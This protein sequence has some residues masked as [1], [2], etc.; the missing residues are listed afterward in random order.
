MIKTA[1]SRHADSNKAAG[2][3]LRRS[4][5]RGE[6][7]VL[8]ILLFTEGYQVELLLEEIKKYHDSK[9]PMLGC[10]VPLLLT[11]DNVLS[12]AVALCVFY[13]EKNSV[14]T[15][16]KKAQ[17]TEIMKT[18]LQAASIL[19]KEPALSS[20]TLLTFYSGISNA[21]LMMKSFYNGLG[22]AFNYIG[23]IG[24]NPLIHDFQI[25]RD[26][27]TAALI[28]GFN[29][30]VITGHGWQ[31]FGEP[32]VLTHCQDNKVYQ[33]N[34]RPAPEVY[35]GADYANLNTLQK[36]IDFYRK[37]PIGIPAAGG[38]HIIRDLI[39]IEENAL[40][41]RNQIPRNTVVTPL[42]FSA[43]SFISTASQMV[44][45]ARP[46]A[47]KPT[48]L[49]VIECIGRHKLMGQKTQLQLRAMQQAAGDNSQ[50]LGFCSYGEVGSFSSVPD[51][52]N[53][54]MVIM[55]GDGDGF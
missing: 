28:S 48:T 55:A 45:K 40:V 27:L 11:S 47:D 5:I 7:P 37:H 15:I 14:K 3:V 2:E 21:S 22:P 50:L 33:I 20:G 39:D 18:A 38:N 42:E 10:C 51:Q 25:K 30:N 23:G 32:M 1:F 54:T 46:A 35:F 19:K 36:K 44:A 53:K 12:K 6:K 8:L 31:P 16:Y 34:G 4:S 9:I 43:E 13:S 29:L 52:Y 49:F 41:F 17:Q 24:H 26:G